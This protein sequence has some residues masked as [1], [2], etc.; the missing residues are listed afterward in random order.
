MQGNA[1]AATV[2]ERGE[3]GVVAP[4][5]APMRSASATRNRAPSGAE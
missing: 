5:C 3:H 4:M 1:D 2:S